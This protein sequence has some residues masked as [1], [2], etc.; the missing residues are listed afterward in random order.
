MW[1]PHWRPRATLPRK[2]P[3]RQKSCAPS[4][5]GSNNP[6]LSFSR[7]P[8]RNWPSLPDSA[9]KLCPSA[10]SPAPPSDPESDMPLQK[11]QIVFSFFSP[12]SYAQALNRICPPSATSN[13][14]NPV[15]RL[16]RKLVSAS[17]CFGSEMP[18]PRTSG[19]QPVFTFLYTFV[20]FVLA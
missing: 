13:S 15:R 11:Q 14:P 16:T 7:R 19:H 17:L 2:G 5:A 4:R 10:L 9:A 8:T 20:D 3:I 12:S 1:L 6:R 18:L